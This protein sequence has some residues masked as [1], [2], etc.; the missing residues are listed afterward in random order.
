MISYSIA[1]WCRMHGISRPI[2]YVLKKRGEG[3]QTFK[4]G[5]LTRISE[6]ANRYWVASKEAEA[7]SGRD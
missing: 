2:F 6:A 5:R 4:V 3:P 7:A 1:E